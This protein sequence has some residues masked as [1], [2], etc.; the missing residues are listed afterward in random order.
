MR[1]ININR[2]MREKGWCSTYIPSAVWW[3]AN[4]E[5]FDGYLLDGEELFDADIG[6]ALWLLN[7]DFLRLVW[8]NG[9][10]DLFK[11][12]GPKDWVLQ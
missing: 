10:T 6:N 11:K 9:T 5:D 12:S 4:P 7:A 8:P 1:T 2:E 3:V